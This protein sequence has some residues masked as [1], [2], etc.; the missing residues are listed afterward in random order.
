MQVRTASGRRIKVMSSNPVG[1]LEN[2]YAGGIPASL[3]CYFFSMFQNT[4]IGLVTMPDRPRVAVGR[5]Y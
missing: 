3:S 4:G 2:A 5:V 1:G